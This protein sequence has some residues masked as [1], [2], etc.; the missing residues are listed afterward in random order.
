[1]KRVHSA[2]PVLTTVTI[3]FVGL[4]TVGRWLLVNDSAVDHLINRAASWNIGS[5]LGY[6]FAAGLGRPELGQRLFMGVGL[7]ALSSCYGFVALLGGA[8]PETARSRQRG[9]D[10]SAALGV[11]LV[12]VCALVEEAGM[13]LHSVFDWERVLWVAIGVLVVWIG[14][15]L[16]YTCIGELRTAATS[17]RERLTYSALFFVGMYSAACSIYAGLHDVSGVVTG[18]PGTIWAVGSLLTMTLLAAL[19]AIPLVSAL[20]VRAGLDRAA[21]HCRRLRP[22]WRD[23]TS[24]VPGVILR[25]ERQS[26]AQRL[27]RMTV[28]IGDALMHLRQFASDTGS[29][30]N[31]TISAYAL[32]IAEAAELKRRGTDLPTRMS[33]P[34]CAIQPPAE[35]R[36]TELRNLLAL[37]RA[38]PR[39]RA[40]A[41]A[42]AAS[43]AKAVTKSDAGHTA[44]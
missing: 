36:G 15:L 35:D 23:L 10:A 42:R 28:E 44:R 26:S 19:V 30:H 40:R 29:T 11:V 5:I 20:A 34:R 14:A 41:R 13:R 8:D 2:P 43:A 18:K 33:H 27:Y 31:D 21:R 3:L 16:M 38:W 22:L 12:L 17:W 24:V 39:A 25:V 9:Y 32:R 37:A 6:A 7:L 1:M 4:I